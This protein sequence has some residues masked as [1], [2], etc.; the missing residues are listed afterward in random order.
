MLY[1]G[2]AYWT[3]NR[4]EGVLKY[5]HN[6]I[7][8]DLVYKKSEDVL[9]KVKAIGMSTTTNQKIE[10]E[11]GDADGEIRTIHHVGLDKD[12]LKILAEADLQRFKYTGYR[13]S[14]TTFG[15]PMLRAGDV[16]NI[17]GNKYHEDGKYFIKTIRKRVGR[18][19]YRQVIEINEIANGNKTASVGSP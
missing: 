13:G 16:A 19:G 2:L 9:L 5:E 12:Q 15:E 1:V 4:K 11:A 10:I 3:D 17:V 8:D 7:D 14:V 18:G 6:I